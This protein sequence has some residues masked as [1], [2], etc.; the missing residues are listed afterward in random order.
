SFPDNGS[1]AINGSNLQ[2]AASFDFEAKSSYSIRVQTTDVGGKT[3]VTT[4]PVTVTNVNEAPTDLALDTSSIPENQPSGSSVGTL[5]TT[6]PDAGGSYTYTLV[7]GTG[8]TDN[9]SFTT[10]GSTLKTT[11]SF[12]FETKN[13]YSIRVRSTDGGGLFVEKALTISVTNVNEAP[14]A[15]TDAYAAI[16]N[17]KLAVGVLGAAGPVKSVAGSVLANDTDPESDA[18][19]VTFPTSSTHGSIL[20]GNAD[21]SFV[22]LPDAGFTGSDTFSYTVSDGA[23]SSSGTVNITVSSPVWYADDSAAAGGTGQST[24]PFNTA[25]A[26]TASSAGQ[27]LFLYAGTYSGGLTLKATQTL[28]TERAGLIV[29]GTSLVPASSGATETLAGGLVLASGNAVQGLDLGNTTGYALSGHNVGTATV[30]TTTAGLISNSTGGAVGISGTTNTLSMTFTSVTSSNS[31]ASGISIAGASGTFTAGSGSSITDA[32]G[33]DVLLSG[34]TLTF[35]HNGTI[36]DDLGQLVAVSSETGGTVTFKGLIDDL[37]NGSG[38]GISLTNNTGGTVAFS[39]GMRL[40]TGANPAFT[41]TG[42]GTVTATQDN[43]AVINTLA[44]TTGTALNVAN[45]TIGGAGLTFRSVNS[46]GAANAVLLNATGAGPFTVTGIGTTAGS[47]GTIT[48]TT[49]DSL[50]LTTTGPVSLSNLNVTNSQ[51]SGILGTSVNGLTLAK[52]SFTGNGNDSGDCGIK[53]SNL[54]GTAAWSDLNVTGSALANVLIDNAS[55]T[56]SSLSVSGASHFD[57]LGTAFGGNSVLVNVH[58]TATL[59]SASILDA[60]FLNNQPARAITVQAQETGTISGFTIQGSTFTNNGLQASF[61]QGG[62][63]NLV[64]SLLNNGTLAFPMT[65]PYTASGTSHAVNVFSSSNSTGGI[66]K[67]RIQGNRIGD[68]AVAGSGS[69]S[70]DGIRAV[71]Q[72]KTVATLLIDSN[73]I[74][75]VPQARGI[76]VQLLGPLDSSGAAASDVTVTNNDVNPQDSTGFPL[77]A[78][79]VAADS[80]GGG[81]VTLRADIRGNTV[82]AGTTFDSLPTF[83]ALDKVVAAAVCQLVDTAP[84]SAD[85]TAQLTSTNTGSASAA[86]GCTLI[87]GPLNTPS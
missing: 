47:G 52:D 62:S 80:Q 78:I 49:S 16:G 65:M 9:I 85:A 84:A 61:E 51:E 2:T 66:I 30:D 81:T 18:L 70:G 59:T 5:S 83:L 35:T 3:F 19:T 20:T 7:A 14:T 15:G 57:S 69:A 25:V 71:V 44:T 10:A 37:G 43:S 63:A 50:A 17:T 82:P 68:A 31:A 36:T 8:A 75:Q 4:L 32:T 48:G 60:T 26:L 42:G 21:G 79:Y 39:G 53:L 27:T 22:Y 33:P 11:A 40:S 56:L 64:F 13:S 29:G 38:G 67:G 76:D 58:G 77:S 28:L 1:F 87:A 54:T 46:A 24:K 12:D 6:D 23:L 41:A 72:G 45:T 73:T 55:G 74:R 86:A 34:G